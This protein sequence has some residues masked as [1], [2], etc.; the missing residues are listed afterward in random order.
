MQEK[1]RKEKQ[2]EVY[3]QTEDGVLKF[4]A[5]FF[6]NEILPYLGIREKPEG[7]APTEMV[8]LELKKMY[9]DFNFVMPEKRWYHFEFES[10][11][12]TL[13]DLKRF[14]EYEAVTS[15]RFG[16]AVTTFVLCSGKKEN[17]MSK[18]TEGINTYRVKVIRL[19]KKRADDVF[20]KLDAKGKSRVRKRDLVPMLLT[21]L[22][23]GEMSEKERILQGFQWLE[24]KYPDVTKEETVK[25]QAVLYSLASKVLDNDELKK[26]KEVVGMTLLGQMLMEDGIRKGYERGCIVLIQTCKEMGLSIEKT[27]EKLRDGFDIS[28]EEAKDYLKR[29]WD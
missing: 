1:E 12:I 18:F 17:Q 5:E 21:P 22:M 13:D 24:A 25:M 11:D 26:V 3:G 7:V 9:Q 19:K 2:P 23:S 8:H 27:L 20:K 28:E 16:V 14:R 6:G 15:R 29:Y 10:D 4:A